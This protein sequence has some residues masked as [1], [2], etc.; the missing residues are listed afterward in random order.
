MAQQYTAATDW[1]IL[2]KLARQ[3]VLN[4]DISNNA[5]FKVVQL[6]TMQYFKLVSPHNSQSCQLSP[7][8]LNSFPASSVNYLKLSANWKSSSPWVCVLIAKS[9]HPSSETL[10]LGCDLSRVSNFADFVFYI[11]TSPNVL[12]CYLHNCL[13]LQCYL[14]N[15]ARPLTERLL[16]VSTISAKTC[17]RSFTLWPPPSSLWPP[18][19]DN[20]APMSAKSERIKLAAIVSSTTNC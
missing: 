15:C 19:V 8:G 16:L 17:F 1:Y 7:L 6:D 3:R 5:A 10:F 4:C 14:P 20:M 9:E 13:V 11:V 12:H 2:N 18:Q